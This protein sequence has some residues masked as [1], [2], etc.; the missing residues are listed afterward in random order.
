MKNL[1]AERLSKDKE[2]GR[3]N[4]RIF[5]GL[6]TKYLGSRASR[7]IQELLGGAINRF[8][9]LYHKIK[10]SYSKNERDALI[11]L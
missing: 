2:E 6:L 4:M 8:F 1:C 7:K 9:N 3:R 5:Q 11:G 10:A